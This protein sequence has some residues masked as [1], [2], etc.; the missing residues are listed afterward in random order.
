VLFLSLSV[1]NPRLFHKKSKRY[2]EQHA[3]ELGQNKQANIQG[4][5][6]HF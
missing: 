6:T 1:S 2:E 3:G 4:L 5:N